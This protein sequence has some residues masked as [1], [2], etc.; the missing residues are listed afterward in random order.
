MARRD[1]HG[2][3][4][5]RPC[6]RF[7]D[8]IASPSAAAAAVALAV[9]KFGGLDIVINNA[10]I[11]RDA[12]FVF[13]ADPMDWEAAIRTNLSAPFYV[14]AAATPVMRDEAKAGRGGGAWGRIV[15]IVSTAGFYGNFGQASSAT[16][17][18][19]SWG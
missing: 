7:R 10:G 12:N 13:K 5:R 14:I 8:S 18:P 3:I 9:E 11:L 6:G 2:R 1:G 17:R 19:G 15:N 16:P 4:A